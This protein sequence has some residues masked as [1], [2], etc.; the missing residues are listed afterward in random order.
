MIT[1]EPNH[2]NITMKRAR[3]LIISWTK[4]LE[5]NH[6][7]AR[8]RFSVQCSAVLKNGLSSRSGNTNPLHPS[9]PSFGTLR[10]CWA[11]LQKS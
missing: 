6:C 4:H 3:V 10:V 5:L 9:S 11:K 8:I 2:M 7:T 1:K